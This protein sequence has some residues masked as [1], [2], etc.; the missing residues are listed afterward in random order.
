M[1]FFQG[2]GG[3]VY[4]RK[5][6]AESAEANVLLLHGFGEHSGHYHRLAFALNA[7]NLDVWA[8]DHLGHGHSD[9]QRGLFGSV[10]VLAS[11]ART[12]LGLSLGATPQ[13][14][15]VIVGHSLGALTGAQL[16]LKRPHAVRG[17]VMTGAPLHGLPAESEAR[18]SP[19]MSLDEVYLDALANDP[20]GF[21][22]APAEAQLWRALTLSGHTVRERLPAENIPVLL[23][24]GERDVFATPARAREFAQTLRHG[25]AI[26]IPGGYHDIPN[27]VAHR[28]V[29][30]LITD[31]IGRWLGRRSQEGQE[32]GHHRATA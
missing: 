29:A 19:V 25:R 12:L 3:R 10:E 9:G 7:S 23:I 31:S 22:T 2:V 27:D 16:T 5:W 24:N 20:L 28:R 1:P 14:P 6:I 11:N 4:Y 21:D 18:N 13:R 15:T 30:A 32:N 17:L 8:L 26:E